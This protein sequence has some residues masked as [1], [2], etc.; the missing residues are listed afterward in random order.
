M[1]ESG[2]ADCGSCRSLA[3]FRGRRFRRALTARVLAGGGAVSI[4]GQLSGAGPT[5][6]EK[7]GLAVLLLTRCN[8]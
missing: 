4:N 5:L 8:W 2:G 6:A 1:P 3:A 7:G